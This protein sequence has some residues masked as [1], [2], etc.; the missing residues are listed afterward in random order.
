M[1]N[2]VRAMKYRI[3]P[4]KRLAGEMQFNYFAQHYNSLTAPDESA[5]SASLPPSQ[6]SPPSPRRRYSSANQRRLAPGVDTAQPIS[7]V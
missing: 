7:A 3:K 1:K 6:S 5:A 4:Q 2:Q